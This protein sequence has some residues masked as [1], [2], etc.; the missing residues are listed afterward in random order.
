MD[1]NMDVW[2]CFL[3]NFE[4]NIEELNEMKILF[5]G[6]LVV[7][8]RMCMVIIKCR[9][10]YFDKWLCVLWYGI[11]NGMRNLDLKNYFRILLIF[12]LNMGF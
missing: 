5:I 6:Y 2:V 9:V 12:I 8:N 11:Y 3:N 10:F 7:L 4:E 1:K